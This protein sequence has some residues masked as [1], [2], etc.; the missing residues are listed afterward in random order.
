MRKA[1]KKRL[2]TEISIL[3]VVILLGAVFFR[4]TKKED[5]LSDRRDFA[6]IQQ[7]GMLR[8]VTDYNNIG[9]F[10]SGD[11]IAGFNYSL[12]VAFANFSKLVLEI[13]VDNNL[14]RNIEGL[15]NQQYDLI[16]RNIPVNISLKNN[17]SF[18]HPIIHNKLVLVQRKPSNEEEPGLIKSH[19]DLAGKTVFVPKSSPAI[20]RLQNLSHEIGDTI[21]IVEDSLYESPQLM[22]KVAAGEIDYSVSDESVAAKVVKQ[23]PEVDINTDIGF[24]HLEA[25]AVRKDSPVLLDSINSWFE[26]FQKT[27]EFRD[28]YNKYYKQ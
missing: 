23:L 11:S 8:V 10:V 5:K 19:L 6:D 16:A 3:T 4:V 24:T 9:Y 14:G 2:L 1:Y 13:S 25:W 21:Y 28:I 17:I 26:Q 7:D 27:K 12:L 18:T 20:L 15:E 22:M